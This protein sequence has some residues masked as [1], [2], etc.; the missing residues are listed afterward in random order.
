LAS[1]EVVMNDDPGCCIR[2]FGA[3]SD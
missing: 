3:V 2:A 1:L